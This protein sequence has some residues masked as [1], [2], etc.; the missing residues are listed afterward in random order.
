LID[1][2]FIL[3]FALVV[4]AVLG[5]AWYALPLLL[6]VHCTRKAQRICTDGGLVALT[7]DDGPSTT[8]T[9]RLLD[10]LDE[11]DSKATFFM[12]GKSI[13]KESELAQ[14]VRSRGHLIAIHSMS[15][16]NVFRCS[17]WRG[18]IDT[19]DGIRAVNRIGVQG[20][21]FRPPYGKA[22]LGTIIASYLYGCSP[23]WW[24]HISGDTC[25][26][27][28]RDAA[29]SILPF[30]SREEFRPK[31]LDLED[32]QEWLEDLA[33][34]G[35]VV[36]LHDGPREDVH[37]HELTLAITRKVLESAHAGGKQMV[38]MNSIASY[39]LASQPKTE[40]NEVPSDIDN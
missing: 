26:R 39:R 29:L 5:G 33:A 1:A 7:F 31:S 16:L 20:K 40:V 25:R 24:T 30:G 4:L 8:V 15:H 23:T 11:H 34:N 18:I 17:P 35:G 14:E 6:R 32:H 2:V 3:V 27:P 12:T 13:A 19:I 21:F 22:T 9:P 38:T 10:L 28:S 37:F 36:L